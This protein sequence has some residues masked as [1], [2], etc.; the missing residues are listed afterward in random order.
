MLSSGADPIRHAWIS[1]ANLGTRMKARTAAIVSGWALLLVAAATIW[2]QPLVAV[3]SSLG[4]AG[5]ALLQ[6][7]FRA[8]EASDVADLYRITILSGC[9]SVLVVELFSAPFVQAL[10]RTLLAP[11]IE[12]LFFNFKGFILGYVVVCFT[13]FTVIM[14]SQGERK[15]RQ[16]VAADR[17]KTGAG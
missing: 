17:P 4:G 8:A 11:A 14:G 3:A 6:E 5:C 15:A 9:V 1:E 16:P 2:V 7:R 12:S 10:G 13:L